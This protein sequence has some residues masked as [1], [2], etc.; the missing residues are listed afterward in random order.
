MTW[1]DVTVKNNNSSG[2]RGNAV[3]VTN[4]SGKTTYFTVS[5]VTFDGAFSKEPIDVGNN[6]AYV[7]VTSSGIANL[8]GA[9]I[10]STNMVRG[11]LTHVTYQ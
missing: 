11:T 1:S 7:T 10:D 8:N 2:G 6:N 3:Y 4:S 5:S 9:S